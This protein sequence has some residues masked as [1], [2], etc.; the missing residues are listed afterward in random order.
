MLSR[1]NAMK[2]Y[3]KNLYLIKPYWFPLSLVVVIMIVEVVF[4]L[5]IA[6][7]QEFFIDGIHSGS[8][9]TINLMIL[10]SLPL[11]LFIVVIRFLQNY[12]RYYYHSLHM[13]DL[14]F[15]VL[16]KMNRLKLPFLR[17]KHTSDYVT[18]ATG[19]VGLTANMFENA[20]LEIIFSLLVII[21]SC[22]YLKDVDL[23]V[24]IIALT[25]GPLIFLMG[26]FFDRTIKNLSTRIQEK[27]AIIRATLQ[28]AVQGL[29]TIKS[30]RLEQYILDQFIVKKQQLNTLLLRRKMIVRSME[31]MI[32]VFT[33]LVIIGITL[34]IC[35]STIEGNLTIGV[36]MSSIYLLIRIQAA[37]S[38]ISL[39]IG[40]IQ[41]G[42]ASAERVFSIIDEEEQLEKILQQPEQHELSDMTY[43]IEI[44]NLNY[45]YINEDGGMREILSNLSF[46]IQPGEKVAIVGPSG[47]GKSTLARLL[48]GL[49]DGYSG[50]LKLLG[51][52]VKE[53]VS[54]IRTQ[55]AY[56]P[57]EA[58]LLPGT[59]R[60]NLM[61][62]SDGK[63]DDEM[64]SAA[65]T[66]CAHSFIMELPGAYEAQISELGKSLSGGQAQR[67]CMARAILA[68]RPVLILDEPTSSL[69]EYH[70]TQILEKILSKEQEATVVIITHNVKTLEQADRIIV[71]DKGKLAAQGTYW[72]VIHNSS[73]MMSEPE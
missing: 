53:H 67:L 64:I 9:S 33:N 52:E 12:I 25:S 58:L 61:L 55:T 43:A 49:Q 4:S 41:V 72:E 31:E 45:D 11:G 19:D 63:T 57:Q 70:E 16:N 40:E 24:T 36:V 5:F 26:R 68:D 10:I 56:V 59:I 27:Q 66:A 20:T 38:T 35:M 22:F 23:L 32:N 65:K 6:K 69:D 2:L 62:G 73:L 29:E 42:I 18:R 39:S 14:S 30:Y 47:S 44:T 15:L 37:Y 71:I 54:F 28:E 13:R 51:K 3:K 48:L 17:Q 50:S 21:C 46:H 34:L 8:I 60:E 7:F 1:K